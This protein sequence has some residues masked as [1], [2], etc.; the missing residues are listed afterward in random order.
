[1]TVTSNFEEL[2]VEAEQNLEG[3]EIPAEWGWLLSTQ[4]SERLLTRFLGTHAVP[5]FNDV[6]HRFVTYPGDPE[7]FYMKRKAQLD[8]VLE[9][10]KPGDIVG[11]VRGRDRDIGKPNPM[12]TWDGW[13]RPCAD[14]LNAPQ[15]PAGTGQGTDDGIPF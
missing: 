8:K 6:Y 12:E 10:A 4:E 14:T 5:P 15:P 11:L 9:N 13:V 2:F 3:Q 7:P 1:M